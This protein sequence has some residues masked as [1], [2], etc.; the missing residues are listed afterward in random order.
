MKP[1]QAEFER[2]AEVIAG[3]VSFAT[4]CH[5]NPDGDCIGALLAMHIVLVKL[6][7]KSHALSVHG[8]PS[9]LRFLPRAEE[10]A[11]AG[12]ADLAPDAAIVLDCGSR[13]RVG[14]ELAGVVERARVVVNIDH[15]LSNSAF[16]DLNYVD[17]DASAACEILYRFFRRCGFEI[18]A[19][20]AKCLYT[21][22]MYDTG[23]FKH[24]TT[25][26]EVFRVCSELLSVGVNP[27][28]IAISVY[29]T[30]NRP[31]LAV[32]GYVLSNLTVSD[33]G[34]LVWAVV[35]RE[36]LREMGATAEDSEG[37]VDQLGSLES[38]EL[39]LLFTGSEDGKVRVNLRSRG[40]VDVS[41][42]AAKFG[43]GGH[44][45]AAGLRS[46]EK[47]EAL[48]EKV[49]RECRERLGAAAPK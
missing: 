4:L 24:P 48:V 28:E 13:K 46:A 8:V 31:H 22:I 10:V 19:D 12:A 11:V 21:G 15:H 37:V 9:F 14:E 49:L 1:P 7:K 17:H 20:V 35:E 29:D 45:S 5:I 3:G 47:M 23:R 30:R 36:R 34:R 40:R 43:G 16:G 18:D 42:I 39:Y 27:S 25:T 44:L 26:P 41:G 2:L 6:G 38:C 32:L 33:G